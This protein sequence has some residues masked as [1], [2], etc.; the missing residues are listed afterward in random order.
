MTF[1]CHWKEKDSGGIMTLVRFPLEDL[2]GEAPVRERDF[3][4]RL[5]ETDWAAY[6]DQAVLV[7]WIHQDEVPIWAYLMVVARL[8]EVA[9]VLSFGEACSPTVLLQR[10]HIQAP[11]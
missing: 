4:S 11:F 1:T 5:N 9:A 6:R 2:L 7:P 3:R 10:R 8:S